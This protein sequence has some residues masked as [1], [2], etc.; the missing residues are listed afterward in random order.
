MDITLIG[1]PGSGKSYVGKKLAEKL[2][3]ECI[4][5]DVVMEKRYN[6]PLQQILDREGEEVFLKKQAEDAILQ[7]T[8]IDNAVIS[9]G[10]SIVYSKDAM[11]H[12]QHVSTIVY[13]EVPF[14]IIE[15]RIIVESR[16]IVGLKNKTLYELFEER[17]LLY[18]K[19]ASFKV[20]GSKDGELVVEEILS[21]LGLS[22]I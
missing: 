14:S 10:G 22:K 21:S 19:Y 15:Q 12:L 3:Y 1:M 17:T 7:T 4:D 18:T 5:L 6:L 8:A 13:I 11:L 2:G 20:D 9:P 16:G